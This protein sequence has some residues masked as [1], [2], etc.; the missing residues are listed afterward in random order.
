MDAQV[1]VFRNGMVAIQPDISK[2][3]DYME[4]GENRLAEVDGRLSAFVNRLIAHA[5]CPVGGQ[6]TV[7]DMEDRSRRDNIR[8]KG[9]PENAETSHAL[10]FLMNAF[11]RWFPN[12]GSVEIMHAHCRGVPKNA[13]WPPPMHWIVSETRLSHFSPLFGETYGDMGIRDSSFK[14]PT[15][16]KGLH[17]LLQRIEPLLVQIICLAD[18]VSC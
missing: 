16:G 10:T 6:D 2:C 12:L 13:G 14:H 1:T 11:P 8:V 7:A 17:G 18:L 5:S 9:V 3:M 15:K 4:N